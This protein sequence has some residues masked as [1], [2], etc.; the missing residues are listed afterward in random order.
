MEYC[1][2]STSG[3]IITEG[4][5]LWQP[6]LYEVGITNDGYIKIIFNKPEDKDFREIRFCL[7][8]DQQELLAIASSILTIFGFEV[9]S[10]T[11]NVTST[12]NGSG[13]IQT[14]GK[15]RCTVVDP[16]KLP[17]EGRGIL[18]GESELNSLEEEHK[19]AIPLVVAHVLKII[20]ELRT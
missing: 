3:F 9:K 11:V 10:I 14:V 15:I 20:K 12:I 13:R 18:F 7:R 16:N 2:G 1:H 19:H 6:D 17:A 8:N 4:K 5:P